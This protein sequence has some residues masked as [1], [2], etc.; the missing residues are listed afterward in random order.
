MVDADRAGM[1]HRGAQHLPERLEAARN[2]AVRIIGGEAPVLAGGIEL[3]GRRADRQPAQHHV[4]VHPGVGAAGID[5]DRGV[6]IEPDRQSARA[7]RCRGSVRAGARRSIAGIRGSRV[8][9]DGFR[10]IGAARRR[11][12]AAIAPAIPA[13]RRNA[14][15]AAFR[16]RRSIRA[17][18]RARPD[19][20]RSRRGARRCRSQQNSDTPRATPR[21]SALQPPDNRPAR[22]R[23]A[24]QYPRDDLRHERGRIPRSPRRRC[25]AD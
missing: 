6:E 14:S 9:R 15:A 19:R 2:Q 11:S 12:A 23:A 24:G 1:A 17:D 21:S 10:A 8:R 18:G 20:R 22:R 4:L 25:R 16:R 7:A 13:M 5:A 3:V